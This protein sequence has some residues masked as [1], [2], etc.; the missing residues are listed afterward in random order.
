FL[1]VVN[2]QGVGSGR[3][4]SPAEVAEI[5]S[6]NELA[7]WLLAMSANPPADA[8]DR[9]VE[10]WRKK[11][12]PAWLIAAMANAPE[13][14]LPELLE[15]ARRVPFTAPAYESVA[16][17]AVSREAARGHADVARNWADR[18]LS[19]TLQRSSRNLILAER[20][21]LARDWSEYLRFGLRRPEPGIIESEGME[22][23]SEG[24]SIP[25]GNVPVFDR[26]MI[27]AFNAQVPLARW[28]DASQ[29]KILPADMQ[30]R[31][32]QVGWLRAVLLGKAEEARKLMRRVLELQP[33]AATV[34]QGYLSA[35]DADE[36]QFAALYLVLRT[37]SLAPALQAPENS[38]LNFGQARNIPSD[39]CWRCSFDRKPDA[40]NSSALTVA[41][42]TAGEAEWRQ[43]RAVEPW[44]ASYL[45]RETL[46]WARTHPDDPRVPEALHRAVL[47]SR[48]RQDSARPQNRLA[49][50]VSGTY[51][52]QA[53]TFLHR[54]YPKS[55]WTARTKYWY[56]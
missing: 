34:A 15:A 33:A 42:R 30:L 53:F 5:E 13:Q 16:Y 48:Y 31:I 56:K 14:D 28:V 36:A 43:I 35:R 55:E 19:H 12:N 20:T 49:E 45:A 7:A 6:T 38:T 40:M 27:D 51:T 2:K 22:I 52:E 37:P 26:D 10:W 54:R 32:A 23:P 39:G 4:W 44:E 50:P 8:G 46:A 24:M 21:R 1:Y 25:P 11:H 29:N 18:A 47:A 3:P 17:Y 41:E 9:S